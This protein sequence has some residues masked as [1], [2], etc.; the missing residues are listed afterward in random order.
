[1]DA[2]LMNSGASPVRVR[3]NFP[4]GVQDDPEKLARTAQLL[5]VSLSASVETRVRP[6]H[7]DWEEAAVKDEVRKIMEENNLPILDDPELVGQNGGSA[8][9][10]PQRG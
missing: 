3:V 8:G 4:D 9:T 6:M 1:M 2:A 10:V 5:A 7:R